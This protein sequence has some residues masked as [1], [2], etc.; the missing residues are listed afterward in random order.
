[1]LELVIL[2][3]SSISLVPSLEHEHQSC[4]LQVEGH[5]R[6]FDHIGHT[7]MQLELELE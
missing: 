5:W 3:P 7:P 4:D 2:V 6:R 1:V